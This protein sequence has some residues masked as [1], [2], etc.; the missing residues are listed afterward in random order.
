MIALTR[1]QLQ[2]LLDHARREVPNEACAVMAGRGERAER[3]YLTANA[4][5]SPYTFSIDPREILRIDKECRENGWEIIAFFHSH[6][7]SQAYPSATDRKWGQWWSQCHHIL[8]S[9]EK[10]EPVFRVFRIGDDGEVTEDRIEVTD[11]G[12]A[13]T[14][15]DVSELIGDTPLLRLR[16]V[17]RG[18]VATVLAKLESSNPGGSVKDR[19]AVAMVQDAEARGLLTPET[20]IVEPTSGNTG[21]ALASIASSRGY[22]LILTMPETMSRD[23]L[24]ML[25]AYGAEVEL[26]PGAEGMAGAV[27]RAEELAASLPRAWMPQQFKNPANVAVHRETTAAEIWRD[28][29]GQ[30]D[31]LVAGVGTGGTITGVAEGI[32]ARKSSLYVVAVEPAESPVL[33]GGKAGPHGIQGI[34]PG[35]VPDILQLDLLDE[36]VQVSAAEAARMTADLARLEGLLVGASS[37]AA[38]QAAVEVARR[39]QNEGKLVV[40]IFPD[41]GERY[42]TTGLFPAQP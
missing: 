5:H 12:R 36:V 34:G 10:P 1:G 33:S 16:R 3:V 14:A 29:Q 30:I 21:I 15:A 22:R 37:G 40:A 6:T 41:A 4:D 9:L 17:T 24:N 27:R 42:L 39:P 19:I 8:V 23:R 31:I 7:H 35:F 13:P 38:A 26:T 2:Q 18:C 25:N 20:V 11:E 32:K 28:T